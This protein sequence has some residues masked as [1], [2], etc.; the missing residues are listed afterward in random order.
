MNHFAFPSF[1]L[2]LTFAL[3]QAACGGSVETTPGDGGGTDT[4]GSQ[5]SGASDQGGG[6]ASGGSASGGAA[7]G[8][9]N[10]GGA[11]AAGGAG[12]GA[13][14]VCAA[15][16]L[17]TIGTPVLVDA[18]GDTVW[19]P[20]ETAFYRV[21]LTNGGADNFFYPGVAVSSDVA[22]VTSSGNT[23]FGL[24]AG[25]TTEL[26]ISVLADASVPIGT[27]VGLTFTVN[28]INEACAGL[29]EAVVNATLE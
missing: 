23:L 25:Q 12:G 18:G 20:G 17:V 3:A 27:E 29:E 13:S 7:T 21:P 11:N 19:S 16:A 10:A 14:E 15:M 28:S 22:A 26:D 4:G 1:A 6:S 24:F 9:A 5:A 8:G 2:S